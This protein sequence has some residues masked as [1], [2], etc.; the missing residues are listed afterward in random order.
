MGLVHRLRNNSR[1]S[2]VDSNKLGFELFFLI[3]ALKAQLFLLNFSPIPSHPIAEL[4]T[5]LNKKA[6]QKKQ[7]KNSKPPPSPIAGDGDGDRVT[8]AVGDKDR[9]LGG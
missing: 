3:L 2:F 6:A 1:N 4:E 8:A 5:K 7:N 9:G